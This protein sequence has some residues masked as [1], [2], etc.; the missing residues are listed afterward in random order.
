[1]RRREFIMLA[2]S[3]AAAWPTAVGSQQS[4]KVYRVGLLTN[5]TL[6][7]VTDERRKTI[8]SGLAAQGFVEGQNLAFEQRSA[9]AQR[10]RLYGLVNELVDANVDV[11]VTFG[12]PPALAAK[13]STKPFPVVVT[14]AGDPVKR[15]LSRLFDHLVGARQHVRRHV[16]T[17]RAR[18]L[19]IEREFELGRLQDWKLAR[20]GA[21]E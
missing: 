2:G 15:T 9:D 8:I 17:E 6:M 18:R 21:F 14:G 13:N 4:G 10:G 11:I 3:A 19:Q 7:G 1:M 20:L 12:Y 5:G 16:E